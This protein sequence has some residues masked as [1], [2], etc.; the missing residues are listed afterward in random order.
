MVTIRPELPD[1]SDAIWRVHEAAFPSADE[2]RLVDALR[3]TG[4]LIVSLVADDGGEIV[5]HIAFSPVMLRDQPVGLGLAPVAVLPAHQ[6]RGIGSRLIREGLDVCKKLDYGF[7]VVL[8]HAEY[9]PRF[10]F[11]RASNYGLGNEYGADESFMVQE[12]RPGGL[13]KAGGLVRYGPAFAPFGTAADS[14]AS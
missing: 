14:S 2:A 3:A 6:R 8:G 12:L 10:G 5:G 1:D 7:V 13:P 9:Y 11:V 4:Q